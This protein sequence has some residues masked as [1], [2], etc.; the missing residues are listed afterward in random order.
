MFVK[1][2]SV[3]TQSG[4]CA[5]CMI[6]YTYSCRTLQRGTLSPQATDYVCCALKKVFTTPYGKRS[7]V[8]VLR[9]FGLDLHTQSTQ[10]VM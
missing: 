9:H 1:I 7:C 2:K 4:A 8:I 5:F 6:S 3:D 10:L